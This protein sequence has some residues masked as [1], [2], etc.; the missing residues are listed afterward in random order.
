MESF[1][2]YIR[3][4]APR[5]GITDPPQI[6]WNDDKER[7]LWHVISQT[8]Q[9]SDINWPLLADRLQVTV[10]FLMQQATLLYETELSRIRGQ[11]QRI[12]TTTSRPERT[13]RCA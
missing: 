7:I 11:M 1:K 5:G 6:E 8:A 3:V 4:D 13:L 2:V 10:P 9:R 12:G